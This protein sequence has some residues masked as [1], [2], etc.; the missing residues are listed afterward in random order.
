MQVI[1]NEKM[2]KRNAKIGSITSLVALG[3]LGIGLY[4][5][6]VYKDL[7]QWSFMALVVG[8]MLSQVGIYFGN[9]WGRH[10]RLDE[11]LTAALKGLSRDYSLYHYTSP[12]NHLLVGPTGIYLLEPY[13]QKGKIMY[14][15]G[16]FKQKGG[17]LGQAYLKIFAQEGLGRPDL[18]I[19]S[20]LDQM[21][22]FFE[23]NG[24]GA[25]QLDKVKVIL[26][27]S[28]KDAELISNDCP[29]TMLAMDSLKGYFR[30][31]EKDGKSSDVA[32]QLTK[33]ALPKESAG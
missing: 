12:V 22:R 15:K 4:I 9:R 17:N 14:E 20:D 2:I 16:K 19:K 24:L 10:P 18:E 25:D 5:S 6:F 3:I 7:A 1:N 21:K 11:R 26:A 28:H 29:Y 27:F 30:A 8:F 32:I 31:A 23:Q 33:D 13:Y